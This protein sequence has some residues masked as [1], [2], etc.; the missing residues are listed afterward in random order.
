MNLCKHLRDEF[1]KL[2]LNMF[3]AIHHIFL[4]IILTDLM[5]VEI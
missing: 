1:L 3:D 2:I 4:T 5:K